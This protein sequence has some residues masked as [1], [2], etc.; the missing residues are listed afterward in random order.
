[1][2]A[3]MIPK[4]VVIS[5]TFIPFATIVGP[6]LP[7]TSIWSKAI[8]MPITVPKNPNEGATAM[9]RRIHEQPFSIFDTCT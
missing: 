9:N 6:M 8:T 1:M 7:A 2:M 4:M 3:T 5:A